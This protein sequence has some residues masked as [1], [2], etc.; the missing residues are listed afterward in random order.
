[1]SSSSQCFTVEI[2]ICQFGRTAQPYVHNVT[3][4]ATMFYS[5]N[6]MDHSMH[7]PQTESKLQTGDVDYTSAVVKIFSLKGQD[8]GRVFLK[9]K[10]LNSA[11]CHIP[12]A[13][14]LEKNGTQALKSS[15]EFLQRFSQ[16]ME[17]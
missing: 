3:F 11:F 5:V 14:L 6:P 4:I 7:P 15:C 17:S 1:M 9:Q 16:Q 10:C 2:V 8:A 13:L 12:S